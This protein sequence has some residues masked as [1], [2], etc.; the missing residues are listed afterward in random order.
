MTLSALVIFADSPAASSIPPGE[1]KKRLQAYEDR[2]TSL[3]TNPTLFISRT[4][5]SVRNLPPWVTDRCLKKLA[6]HSVQAFKKVVEAGEM[7]DISR[8]ETDLDALPAAEEN[9]EDQT[10]TV[11]S[12]PKGKKKSFFTSK[13]K[14]SLV[15]Q[16][17]IARSAERLDLFSPTGAGKSNGFGFLEMDKHSDALRVLRWANNRP[18]TVD[19][20]RGWWKDE[21]K[22]N[23]AKLKTQA[24]QNSAPKKVGFGVHHAVTDED[25][26]KSK[27]QLWERT[28]KEMDLEDAS[29]S[30]S[31]PLLVEFS[32]ENKAVVK[33]RAEKQVRRSRS[34]ISERDQNVRLN[35]PSTSTETCACPK[36]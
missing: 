23:I 9:A 14:T 25:G 27:L 16:A 33:L 28:L 15:K 20:L 26:R 6:S 32:I 1:L 18:G 11:K 12:H 31:K 36:T 7:E 3:R 17:K 4:R 34:L 30:W 10:T 35:L 22:E 2:R 13:N 24:Q 8:A 29:R 19:L 21:L 5:L